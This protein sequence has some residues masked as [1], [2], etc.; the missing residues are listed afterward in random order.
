MNPRGETK[1]GNQ[2]YLGDANLKKNCFFPLSSLYESMKKR[3]GDHVLKESGLFSKW[4]GK[5]GCQDARDERIGRWMER[6]R[7][8]AGGRHGLGS[9]NISCPGSEKDAKLI[10]RKLC[11]CRS[12][13]VVELV[14]MALG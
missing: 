13:A 9:I 7:G 1:A 8:L 2:I 5:D 4:S 14:V 3:S 6:D 11:G 12:L 10:F